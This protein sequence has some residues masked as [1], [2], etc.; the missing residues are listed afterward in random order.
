MVLS[1][2]LNYP[3]LRFSTFNIWGCL[4]LEVVLIWNF[5][6]ED[7]LHFN[8][9]VCIPLVILFTSNIWIVWF[10]HWMVTPNCFDT[11]SALC[12]TCSVDFKVLFHW[13][14]FSFSFLVFCKLWI[15]EA[16]L[17]LKFGGKSDHWLFRYSNYMLQSFKVIF[18]WG[19]SSF[20]AFVRFELVR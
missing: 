6:C 4:P 19:M 16:S 5:G 7:I 13:R 11:Y 9:W 14:L 3:V 17:G 20:Q 18:Q 10:G 15:G 2:K 12:F 1:L 8:I